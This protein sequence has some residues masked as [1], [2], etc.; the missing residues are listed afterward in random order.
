MRNDA[1][2]AGNGDTIR[3]RD[4]VR[5]A[6]RLEIL[7][8]GLIRIATEPKVPS[9]NGMTRYA[10]I[11]ASTEK[12]EVFVVPGIIQPDGL[13]ELGLGLVQLTQEEGHLPQCIMA[14]D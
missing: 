6:K 4:F 14:L 9:D 11:L 5:E 1:E 3:M 7:L 10:R 12:R 8:E 2:E 13:I